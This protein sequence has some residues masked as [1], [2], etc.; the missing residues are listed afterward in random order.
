MRRKGKK[1]PSPKI[2][3]TM[4]YYCKR[5]KGREGEIK[6]RKTV[7]KKKA[8]G[9]GISSSLCVQRF[10]FF[11]HADIRMSGT[12]YS[13]PACLPACVVWVSFCP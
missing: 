10:C 1:N 3:S 11:L 5:E 9:R 13:M 7:S 12:M 4:Y 6:E 8:A 2:T